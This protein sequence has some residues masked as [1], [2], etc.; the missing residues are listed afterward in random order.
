MLACTKANCSLE[1]AKRTHFLSRAVL[2][3][4]CHTRRQSSIHTTGRTMQRGPS[5]ITAAVLLM[6]AVVVLMAAGSPPA[7]RLRVF[8]LSFGG[9]DPESGYPGPVL[10]GPLEVICFLG[11][12]T[13]PSPL[14]LCCPPSPRPVNVL[15]CWWHNAVFSQG[16]SC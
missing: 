10:G 5:S 14:T 15:M 16:P 2:G 9:T 1:R 3:P 13:S 11:A 12:C 7:P 8:G 4:G 6:C